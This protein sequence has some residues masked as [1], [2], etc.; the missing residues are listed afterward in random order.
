[1][2]QVSTVKDCLKTLIGWV[3]H[4]DEE[5][6]PNFPID[7]DLLKTDSGQVYNNMHEIMNL[8]IINISIPENR[9]L[10]EYLSS[11]EESAIIELLN[12]VYTNKEVRQAGKSLLNDSVLINSIGGYKDKITGKG[13]F[14]GFAFRL[15]HD[16][17]LRSTIKRVG[18]QLTDA[19]INPLTLYLYHSSKTEAVATLEFTSSKGLDFTF[20]DSDLELIADSKEITGGEYKLGYY[21]SDLL[22]NQAIDYKLLNYDTGFCNACRGGLDARRYNKI[23]KY[24][25]FKPFYVS[26]SALNGVIKPDEE[27]FNYTNSCNFGL[28]LSV[29]VECDLSNFICDNKLHLRT[30]LGYKMVY[31]V[32]EM[33][34]YSQETNA[35]DER[36]KSIIIR[37]LEGDVDTRLTTVQQKYDEA[38]TGLSFNFSGLNSSCIPCNNNSRTRYRVRR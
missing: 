29:S 9:D 7:S 34:K 22:T 19:Q 11:L 23:R 36:L 12:D 28:N 38:L 13:R 16:I 6:V 37:D 35:P 4:Y 21:E 26:S 32:L 2:F 15:R 27:D 3:N 1:M 24:F 25:D 8:N 33:V 18:L 5:E 10:E 30:A 17:G 20:I 14:V 31:K